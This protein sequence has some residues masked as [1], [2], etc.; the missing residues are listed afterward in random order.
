MQRL[1]HYEL[2]E[3]RM[4]RIGR[5][6]YLNREKA[7]IHDGYELCETQCHV[8]VIN[9]MRS[10]ICPSATSLLNL[11]LLSP[12][13]NLFHGKHWKELLGCLRRTET[14]YFF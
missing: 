1:N 7:P 5:L 11:S 9:S 6:Q 8:Y 12:S 4:T 14:R 3:T 13:L 2:R 10:L